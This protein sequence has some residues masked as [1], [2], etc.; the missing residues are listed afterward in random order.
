MGVTLAVTFSKWNLYANG[1][2]GIKGALSNCSVMKK[3][4]LIKALYNRTSQQQ[5]NMAR[6]QMHIY[7]NQKE[8]IQMGKSC[9]QELQHFFFFLMSYNTNKQWFLDVEEFF[10]NS[11]VNRWSW[12]IFYQIKYSIK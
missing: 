2:Y 7:K 4:D 3:K 1:Y 6:G 12:K 8:P 9:G 5:P 10:L 11:F